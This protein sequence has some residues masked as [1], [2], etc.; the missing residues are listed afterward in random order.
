MNR[1]NINLWEIAARKLAC[2]KR[3]DLEDLGKVIDTIVKNILD[4]RS[5]SKYRLC[6]F[7]NKVIA[8]RFL[9]R[10]GGVETLTAF[11][12]M[13]FNSET[14]GKGL[15]LLDK[16]EAPHDTISALETGLVWFH[17]TVA[18]MLRSATDS[19]SVCAE[20]LISFKMPVGPPVVGGFMKEET[21]SSVLSYVSNFFSDEKK[22]RI[23]L[24][25]PHDP[26]D[27]TAAAT[28]Q[29]TLQEM[30]LNVSRLGLVAS[31]QSDKS[32][33]EALQQPQSVLH[34]LSSE[35]P[36]AVRSKQAIEVAVHLSESVH[37][38]RA[39]E[40]HDAPDANSTTP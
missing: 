23:T 8:R 33:E 26:R 24:R 17:E 21:I 4:H 7:S 6:K 3:D 34:G 40:S 13:P 39:Q 18:S 19:Q 5:E 9:A 30:D 14:D 32:R 31:L 16:E 35:G 22:A 10:E 38:D 28:C 15:I 20:V 12:F 36:E 25:Q 2:N 27:L 11:G 37:K 29:A 1:S